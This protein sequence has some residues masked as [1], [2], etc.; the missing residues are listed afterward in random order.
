M[1]KNW[2]FASC[3]FLTTAR[4]DRRLEKVSWSWCNKIE[5]TSVKCHEQVKN[6]DNRKKIKTS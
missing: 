2:A 3:S 5:L 6:N 1:I 4:N